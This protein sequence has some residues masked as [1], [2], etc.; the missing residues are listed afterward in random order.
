MPLFS[1]LVYP[2][3]A[4]YWANLPMKN[5]WMSYLYL[6]SF[7]YVAWIVMAT[8]YHFT[9]NYLGFTDPMPMNFYAIGS[10]TYYGMAFAIV[11]R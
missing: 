4:E 5:G 9:G 11:L 1:W 2:N 10:L 8:V 3:H 6:T 7:G